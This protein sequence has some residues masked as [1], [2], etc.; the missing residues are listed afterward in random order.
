M[1]HDSPQRTCGPRAVGYAAGM[2]TQLSLIM[3]V[4]AAAA[5]GQPPLPGQLAASIQETRIRSTVDRLAGFGTRHSLSVDEG[6]T[7]GIRAAA[8]WLK[9]ELDAAG[10]PRT[11]LESVELPP[12]T[13]VPKGGTF[14]NV[15]A[16]IPG[17]VTPD[18]RYYVVAHMDSMP[19][20]VM[21]ATSDAPGANDNASGT[22]A[23]AEIA[24]VF[25]KVPLE[26]TVV[27]LLTSGEEQGLL[28]AKA[29]AELARSRGEDIR[30]VLNNDIIGDPLG[31]GGDPARTTRNLIRVLS[32]GLPRNPEAERL[33]QI[34][35]LSS[36][37]DGTSRQLARYVAEIAR[38]EHTAVQPMLVF[39]PD[40]FLRGG[41]HLPFNELGIAAV[42][43]CEVHEDY[44][45]QHQNVRE[46]ALPSGEKVKFG[47]LPEHV[48]AGY[49]A[50]VA[51]LNL[52][53]LVHLANAPSIPTRVRIITA[54]LD[55]K[56]TIRWEPSPESDVAG[57]EV[58]W[59]LTTE[60]QWTNAK[61]VG[62]VTEVTIDESKDNS[63]FGVR[64]YDRD[65]YRSPVAF[66]GAARE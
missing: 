7:R 19:T 51:R 25:G 64:A 31:P 24:R 28:G 29:H 56:T 22:A 8:R 43:F 32:E 38:L 1:Q 17:T 49:V 55:T 66:C 13:R 58:V 50:D 54:K 63:F 37:S 47:D 61:D 57:Y 27:V 15:V 59:R 33:A 16:T 48:D 10:V 62:N 53:T 2:L 5:C 14:V 40:R 3:M 35:A 42:R 12:S 65:G 11:E 41:D 26:S 6:E 46:E 52:V 23:A 18:R 34:R 20:D 60:P 4:G 21:D 36:E 9:S 44:T 30:A 45:K 39:R